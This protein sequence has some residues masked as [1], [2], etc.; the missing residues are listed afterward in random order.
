[1]LVGIGI[2]CTLYKLVHKVEY[3]HCSE[4]FT[5]SKS[6][7]HMVLQKFV[8]VV[9]VVFK[10]QIKWPKG[11]DLKDVMV[12]FKK[13]CDFPSVHNAINV[14]QICTQNHKWL[15]LNITSL[16][17]PKLTTCSSKLLLIIKRIFEMFLL[18]CLAQ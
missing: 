4:M 2:A 1:M 18:V 17:N 5:I 7:I 14:I 3:F 13:I 10:N 16:S 6:T 11:K 8:H 15:S 12:G 9:N